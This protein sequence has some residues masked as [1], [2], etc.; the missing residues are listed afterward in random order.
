MTLMSPLWTEIGS[1]WLRLAFAGGLLLLAGLVLIVAC[2]RPALRLRAGSWTLVTA[3]MLLPLTLLPGWFALPW[4]IASPPQPGANKS[5]TPVAPAAAIV[6]ERRAPVDPGPAVIEFRPVIV[7]EPNREPIRE[8]QAPPSAVGRETKPVAAAGAAQ[9]AKSTPVLP[10]FTIGLLLA[11]ALVVFTLLGRLARGQWQLL[12]LW[13]SGRPA[14][15]AV[16]QIFH[17]LTRRYRVKPALRVVDC[18]AGP[19]CFGVF[20]PRIVLP[21]ALAESADDKA[22][23]WVFAHE[24]DHLARRDP[25]VGWLIGFAQALFFFWPWFWKLRRVLRLNQ[26]YLADAAAVKAT[27]IGN[28]TVPAPAV[29]YADFLVRLT[30]TGA[31]PVGAAGVKTPSSDLYRRVTMLL[32]GSGNLDARCPRRWSI[33]AGGGLLA[34]GIVLAG[35]QFTTRQVV[36]A[37]DK[38]DKAQPPKKETVEDVEEQVRK[39]LEALKKG[40]QPR[41]EDDVKEPAK[42]PAADRAKVE[43]EFQKAEDALKKAQKAM[44]DN[45]GDPETGR[46]FQEAVRKYQEA[47]RARMAAPQRIG[48]PAVQF[49]PI[50]PPDVIPLPLPLLPDNLD[51]ELK[52]LQEELQKAMEEMQ[53]QMQLQ[54]GFQPGARLRI[55]GNFGPNMLRTGRLTSDMRLGVRVE[56]PTAALTEQLDLPLNKG[57]VVI[58]VHPESAAAKA[59]IKVSDIILEVD[60]KAVSSEAADLQDTIRNFKADQKVDVVV[61]RKGKKETIKGVVIPEAKPDRLDPRIQFPNIQFPQLPNLRNPNGFPPEAFG[62]INNSVRS[63]VTVN[64]G[65]FTIRHET[66]DM[67]VTVVGNKDDGA[68]KATSI[69]IEDNGK[70]IK[71]ES[72]EKLDKQ[73]QPLVEKLLKQIR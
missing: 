44:A 23:R 70:K 8:P 52:R 65:E 26:E 6:A 28:E 69:E 62:G 16:R 38:T 41:K 14:P 13:H 22:L 17:R 9:P 46:A 40:P 58:E 36:A 31:V 47:F 51:P 3:L 35:L 25:L 2:R 34:L 72:L 39:A 15:V 53:K 37:D 43:D 11:Y 55:G 18:L 57:I 54:P 61:L 33:I 27:N 49:P 7:V 56:R 45:P 20:R 24:L 73:Y 4:S 21:A 66:D 68:P 64:N 48:R 32:N 1:W 59:G 42:G 50:Q 10:W 71:A 19:I 60:G 29:D 12:R 30:S 5:A 67:K 63:S